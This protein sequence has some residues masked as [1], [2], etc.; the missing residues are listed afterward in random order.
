MDVKRLRYLKR[1]FII[2]VMLIDA[3]FGMESVP[4]TVRRWHSLLL[5]SRQRT[6]E[7]AV[8]WRSNL[9]TWPLIS[10]GKKSENFQRVTP[11]TIEEITAKNRKFSYESEKMI[12]RNLETGESWN[13]I[14]PFCLMTCHLLN[15]QCRNNVADFMDFS[16]HVQRLTARLVKWTGAMT[17]QMEAHQA[18]DEGKSWPKTLCFNSNIQGQNNFEPPAAAFVNCIALNEQDSH[19]WKNDN[20]HQI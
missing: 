11:H 15:D 20:H 8:R 4:G 16:F 6:K 5:G 17:E 18:Q 10:P 9:H 7:L 2:I 12:N 1:R 3:N 19:R 14:S 13:I